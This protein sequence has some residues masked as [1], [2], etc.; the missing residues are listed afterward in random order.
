MPLNV[1]GCKYHENVILLLDSLH[2]KFPDVVQLYS[3]QDEF[4][5]CQWKEK[6]GFVQNNLIQGATNTAL[7]D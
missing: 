5:W 3:K 4:K 1:C 6:Y 7:S 2:K